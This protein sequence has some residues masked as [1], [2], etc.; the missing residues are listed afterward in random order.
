LL[1]IKDRAEPKVV[2]I[3]SRLVEIKENIGIWAQNVALE[4]LLFR[5]DGLFRSPFGHGSLFRLTQYSMVS[6]KNRVI[7]SNTFVLEKKRN[8]GLCD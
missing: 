7:R 8:A 3:Y 1:R 2:V 5:F 6:K 4:V